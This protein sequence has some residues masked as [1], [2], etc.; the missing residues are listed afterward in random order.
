MFFDEEQWHALILLCYIVRFVNE[1]NHQHKFS[2]RIILV[3][4]SVKRNPAM[5]IFVGELFSGPLM[6]LHW[7]VE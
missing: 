2:E 5:I 6:V 7:L 4:V 1:Y 3:L